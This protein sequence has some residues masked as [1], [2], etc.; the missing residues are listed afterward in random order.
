[1]VGSKATACCWMDVDVRTLNYD[2]FG[3]ERGGQSL[4]LKNVAAAGPNGPEIGLEL[5]PSVKLTLGRGGDLLG[6]WTSFLDLQKQW[7]IVRQVV[8]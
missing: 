3:D 1:M 6:L 8:K 4:N 7:E 5:K 2:D